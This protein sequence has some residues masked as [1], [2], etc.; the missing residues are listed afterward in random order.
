M[1]R[2]AFRVALTHDFRRP[3][4]SPTIAGLDLRP[5]ESDPRVEVFYLDPCKEIG[6]EQLAGANA[7]ILMWPKV[8]ARS[9]AQADDLSVICRFGVGFDNVDV[10]AATRAGIAVTNTPDAV[11]RPVAVSILTLLFALTSYLLER[12]RSV[13]ERRW[14]TVYDTIGV[15]LAGRTLGS[16]GM[17][18][19]GA[20]V[21]RL[22]APFG[23]RF[24]A[25]D[26]YVDPNL[27][28]G[29]GVELVELD[30]LFRQADFINISV[31]LLPET[32]GLVS[33]KR[34]AL[35]K[36]S[37][38]LINTARGAIVDQRALTH[39]LQER[40]IAGAGLDVFEKEPLD[41]DDPILELDNVL[42]TPHAL[43]ESD[44]MQ[45]GI[46]NSVLA[47]VLA[48]ISGE[49]PQYIVNRQVVDETAF[50]K[51]LESNRRSFAGS[52]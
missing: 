27:A 33:A 17:G 32:Q 28:A 47:S 22:A 31:P 5:L 9:L 49:M 30:D 36:P 23:M 52:P 50:K 35:M 10:A 19:I 20:E 7:V 18:N 11:R 43:S 8:T 39:A 25:H 42:L 46:G 26:P 3:D 6:P 1:K 41:P 12:D 40:R 16:V 15:G 2:P 38:F 24:M 13:R 4:G 34:I 48:V 29:L 51:K 21:F 44:Q 14:H 37:A 45:S